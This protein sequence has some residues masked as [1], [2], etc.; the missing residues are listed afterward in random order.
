M[1]PYYSIPWP[2]RLR[3]RLRLA[4]SGLF[5]KLKALVGVKPPTGITMLVGTGNSGRLS[6]ETSR[7]FL[8][9][10]ERAR[11]HTTVIPDPEIIRTAPGIVIPFT[12][13][14]AGDQ[15]TAAKRRGQPRHRHH[16]RNSR[17]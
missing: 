15:A 6:P 1:H 17:R 13:G 12:Q 16:R 14:H 3:V 9:S 7:H 8:V 5:P 4:A 11:E 10:I 2:I